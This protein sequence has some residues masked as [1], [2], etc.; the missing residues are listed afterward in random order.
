MSIWNNTNIQ[1]NKLKLKDNLELVKRILKVSKADKPQFIKDIRDIA[2][3]TWT[4]YKPQLEKFTIK[5][6]GSIYNKLIRKWEPPK[7]ILRNT[8]V[9]KSLKQKDSVIKALKDKNYRI[10][11]VDNK[12]K[13]KK[14]WYKD[15]NIKLT[16]PSWVKSE[17]ILIQ[18]NMLKAKQTIGYKVYDIRKALHISKEPEAKKYEKK[19]TTFLNDLFTKAWKKDKLRLKKD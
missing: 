16:N 6:E 12:F 3:K 17:L 14:Y 13:D 18:P 10:K 8:L 4:Q 9:M 7:D 1:A 19:A 5:S 15:V 2:N 11:E